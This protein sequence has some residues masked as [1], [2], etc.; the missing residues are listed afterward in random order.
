MKIGIVGF[1]PRGL[2]A[3]ERI[4]AH[5]SQVRE[6]IEIAVFDPDGPGGKVWRTNQPTALVIN[7]V[8]DQVTLFTDETLS[9][10][11]PV[12]NGPHLYDWAKTVAESFIQEN[13]TINQDFFLE[14]ARNLTANGHCSR[15]FYGLYQK[16]IYQNIIENLPAHI[17][18]SLYP[19]EV[20]SLHRNDQQFRLDTGKNSFVFD[21]V[22]L[23]LGHH[24]TAPTKQEKE[25]AAYAKENNLIYSRAKNA[26]DADFTQIPAKENIIL[27][28]LGLSFFDYVTMLTLGRGGSYTREGD[29]LVYQTSGNEPHI[30]AGS[31][32]GFPYHPRGRN[33][34]SYGQSYQPNFLTQERLDSWLKAGNVTGGEFFSLLKK[35]LELIYYS[36]LIEE[37]QQDVESFAKAFIEATGSETVLKDFGIDQKDWWSWAFIEHPDS[38]VEEATGFQAFIK[39]YV[40]WDAAEAQKGN[41]EGPVSAAFESLKD[42]RDQ[43]R[44]VLDHQLL[45]PDDLLDHHWGWFVPLNSFLSIGPP[46]H[47]TEELAA[48]MEAG[49]VTLLGP[50][51]EVNTQEGQFIATAKHTKQKYFAKSLMEARLPKTAI[52]GTSNPLLRQTLNDELLLKHA[53]TRKNGE[54]EYTGAV[55]VDNLTNHVLDKDNQKIAGLFCYGIPTEGLHW[56]TAATARPGTNPW[57]LRES[58]IIAQQIFSEA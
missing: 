32:R 16:W 12:V 57:N 8:N 36:L 20:Q 15:A 29:Q 6:K 37:K 19:E 50:E 35:E 53:I 26:A 45:T 34:K 23:A 18:V 56:L 10:G 44:F 4:V 58:D 2:S 43:V 39:D 38:F 52:E 47:R 9:T 3:L 14:E 11:G 25:L 5:G 24:E 27:K 48:L 7:S 33:Q 1:G 31:G 49:I 55:L 30:I 51:L 21:K 42:M 28:G 17:D 22:I 46:V 40:S 54:T 13:V 41:Q